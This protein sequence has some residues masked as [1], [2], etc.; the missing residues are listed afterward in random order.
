MYSETELRD[1]FH[2]LTA[3]HDAIRAVSDP[4]RAQRDKIVQDA[5]IKARKLAE[6]IKEAEAGLYDIEMER[7]RIARALKGKTG[8]G[9]S[10]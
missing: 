9:S 2:E 10:E 3:Q 8:Y 1:R 5:D 4:I 6:Q 7:A